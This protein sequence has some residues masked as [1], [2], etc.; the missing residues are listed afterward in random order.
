MKIAIEIL[1][2]VL[3][4]YIAYQNYR[5][6]KAGFFV[7]KD[8][9]RLDLFDRRY[10]VF[11][12]LRKLLSLFISNANFTRVELQTFVN[13]SSDAEFLFGK[14][15]KDYVDEVKK[16]GLKLAQLHDHFLEPKTLG[17]RNDGETIRQLEINE[18]ESWF[19][20]QFQE[21]GNLFKKYLHFS[22]NKNP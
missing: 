17:I 3:L 7:Q 4:T 8:K 10:R 16:R 20:D 18:L 1:I 11:E 19:K 9:L 14:D 12:A 21:Y 22:I 15:I 5:I 6:S 13:D 2:S